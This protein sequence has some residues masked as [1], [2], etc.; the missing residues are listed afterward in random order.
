MVEKCQYSL[1]LQGS[2]VGS[3]VVRTHKSK[4]GIFLDSHLVLQGNL[5]R[6]VVTQ[7]SYLHP[8]G[9]H[10]L[11]FKEETLDRNQHSSWNVSFDASSG[12]VTASRNKND[13]VS[14]PYILPFQDPLGLLYQIRKLKDD[15]PVQV[16]MLGKSVFVNLIKTSKLSTTLGKYDARVYI[17]H[18]GGSYVYVDV[19]PPNY[20]L[21]LTQKLQ[22]QFVESSLIKVS[23][24][25]NHLKK[26]LVKKPPSS[27]T[28]N[29]GR[30]KPSRKRIRETKHNRTAKRSPKK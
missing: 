9:L 7:H 12:L 29:S 11:S 17:L 20:I 15:L 6:Q 3:Y 19:S 25:E 30:K 18:P 23:E 26:N 14:I 10:S 1:S 27:S 22:H 16:P 5:G 24:E 13:V 2:S 8:S 4:K 21:K 28:S